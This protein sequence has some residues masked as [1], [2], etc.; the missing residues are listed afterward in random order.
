MQTF[1]PGWETTI[2]FDSEDI[3]VVGNVL[4]FVRTKA[5]LP[6][7]VFGSQFRHEIPG[8][9]GGSISAEGHLSAEKVQA[10]EDLFNSSVS[11]PYVIQAGTAAGAT[12]GGAWS[13]LMVVNE[14]TLDTDAEDQWSWSI[15]AT[16]DGAPTYT[17][18][19]P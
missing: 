14:Y 4:S 5:A 1:I 18:A 2:T 12:D 16:L 3:T 11:V 9:A 6:K 17:P 19:A 13:G 10:L 15:N 8:Q 7:P